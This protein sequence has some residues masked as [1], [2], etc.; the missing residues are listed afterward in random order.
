M[1][2]DDKSAQFAQNTIR[3]DQSPQPI[4][5]QDAMSTKEGRTH[6]VAVFSGQSV[7]SDHKP[8]T[9]LASPLMN[10]I[11]EHQKRD[12]SEKLDHVGW[13][14]KNTASNQAIN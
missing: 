2:Q 6:P 7:R 11:D 13:D 9:T 10:K 4:S 12:S 14:K 3:T 1:P 5:M 8:L